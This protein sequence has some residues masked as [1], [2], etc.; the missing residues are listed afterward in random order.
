VGQ[1]ATKRKMC[2]L[3][4]CKMAEQRQTAQTSEESAVS[5]ERCQFQSA[6]LRC[7]RPK[8]YAPRGVDEKAACLMHSHDPNKSATKFQAEFEHILNE[9][10]ED[11]ANFTGFV[12]PSSSY[13]HREFKARCIFAYATFR[14]QTD[15]VFA[16]FKQEADF[17]SATFSQEANFLG[18]IF[19]KSANF[20]EAKFGSARFQGATFWQ[21]SNFSVAEFTDE[22]NFQEITF[23]GLAN[24]SSTDFTRKVHFERSRFGGA[25]RFLETKFGPESAD[26]DREP[27]GDLSDVTFENPEQ[28]KFFQSSL[29]NVLFCNCDLS[30]VE[31]S[32]VGWRQRKN[33]KSM[34]LDE[35]VDLLR[36]SSLRP[37]EGE[38]NERNYRLIAELYQQLKGNYD[39]RA[40]YGKAGDFHFGELE[41]KRL[42]SRHKNELLRRL[43]R[44][45]GLVAWYKY[46]SDYGE[47]YVKPGLW[48]VPVLLIFALFYPVTGLYVDTRHSA[49]LVISLPTQ[50]AGTQNSASQPA[51]VASAPTLPCAER[52]TYWCPWPTGPEPTIWRARAR[53]FGNGL[54]TSL[55]VAAFQKDLTYQP[56]YPWGR[57]LAL[58]EVLLT[59]TLGAL[60]LLA[61]RRQFKR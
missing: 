35:E 45:L 49:P 18:A 38:P 2:V 58:I 43:Q 39:N 25:A 56:S 52:M 55:D 36:A 21:D 29:R 5:E 7:E 42:Y 48:F 34:V 33:G 14:Q 8:H 26:R 4:S 30:K 57:L 20:S 59:S 27:R 31:F 17:F 32:D 44:N 12:F 60:F 28:V 15:F 40:D 9:A 37:S 24:F 54:V 53:L 1:S 47:S 41:M 51:T 13:N 16:T 10:G 3:D 6:G 46:A 50:P 11:A 22:A 19:I 23:K 61:V